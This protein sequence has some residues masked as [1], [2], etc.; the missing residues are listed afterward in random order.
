MARTVVGRPMSAS[1]VEFG[2][3]MSAGEAAVAP[4]WQ[5]WAIDCLDDE[6]LSHCGHLDCK[7][8]NPGCTYCREIAEHVAEHRLSRPDR[9]CEFCAGWR[10]SA[11]ALAKLVWTKEASLGSWWSI[12]GALWELIGCDGAKIMLRD[13]RG[14]PRW[15]ADREFYQLVTSG[16]AYPG[17][18]ASVG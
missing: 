9:M 18:G 6:Q 13:A 10:R 2:R 14:A 17:D 4:D 3:G 5:S 8:L 15:V 12:S 16:K 1:E 11:R 7:V